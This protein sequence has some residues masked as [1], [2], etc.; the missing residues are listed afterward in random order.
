MLAQ[1]D[2][3]LC[4]WGVWPG[5]GGQLADTGTQGEPLRGEVGAHFRTGIEKIGSHSVS[6]I[7]KRG[8]GKQRGIFPLDRESRFP[9]RHLRREWGFQRDDDANRSF[10]RMPWGGGIVAGFRLP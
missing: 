1:A 7:Q 2:G 8:I 4:Q 5:L 10:F 9:A 3:V 6:Y